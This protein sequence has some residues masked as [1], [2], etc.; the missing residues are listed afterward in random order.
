MKKFK[1]IINSISTIAV[2]ASLLF[3]GV[4]IN[5][6]NQVAKATIRQS[7]NETDMQIYTITIDQ[8]ALAKADY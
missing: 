4:Q 5:Q 2:V 6:S 3:V 1:I 8:N 7:L